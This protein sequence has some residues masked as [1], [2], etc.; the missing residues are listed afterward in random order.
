[1]VANKIDLVEERVIMPQKIAEKALQ[2]EANSYVEVSAKT[3]AGVHALFVDIA[4]RCKKVANSI[5]RME[6]LE[7]QEL[8]KIIHHNESCCK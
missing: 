8:D 5:D 4:R 6:T 3:G 2:C 7:L 1:M